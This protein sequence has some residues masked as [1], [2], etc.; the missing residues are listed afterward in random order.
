MNKPRILIV[1]DEK[2]DVQAIR[3]RLGDLADAAHI[4][5]QPPDDHSIT[6]AQKLESLNVMAGGLAH[7]F[8]NLLTPI[9]GFSG[10]IRAS[11]PND[12]PLVPMAAQIEDAARRAAE[13][14]RDMLAYSGK[15]RSAR[16]PLNLSRMIEDMGSALRESVAATTNLN[17]K[18]DPCPPPVEGDSEQLRQVILSLVANAT[19]SL[20]GRVGTI[21]LRTGVLKRIA[22]PGHLLL[23]GDVP[24]GPCVSL[25]VADNGCGIPAET[26]PKVFDPFFTTK[27]TGR[28]LGLAASLGIVRSHGGAIEVDS[29]PSRGTTMRL[30]FPVFQAAPA[31]RP[32]PAGNGAVPLENEDASSISAANVEEPRHGPVGERYDRKSGDNDGCT[33]DNA[34]DSGS[35]RAGWQTQPRHPEGP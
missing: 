24:P 11:L 19:E 33:A 18:L 30:F 21:E 13:M 15:A 9:L 35:G 17:F 6:Y 31:V 3:A 32:A 1:A 23:L 4:V 25:E 22:R 14:V 20:P 8:N 10:L 29:A 27:F 28:G 7:G 12:S 5:V 2:A 26:L 16:A 34:G